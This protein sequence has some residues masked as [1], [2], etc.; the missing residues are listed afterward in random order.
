MDN[1]AA[2]MTQERNRRYQEFME[3]NGHCSLLE[4][5]KQVEGLL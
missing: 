4:L 3:L 2:L 1:L 5:G